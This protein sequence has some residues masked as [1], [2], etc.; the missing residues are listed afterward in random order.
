MHEESRVKMTQQAGLHPKKEA[1]NQ[2]EADAATIRT[3][4]AV[5]KTMNPAIDWLIRLGKGMLIG[6]GAILPGLSGGALS[7]IFGI[8][9]P[10]LAFLANLRHRFVRNV[11]FF[12][13]VILGGGL[14]ILFFS[15]VVKAAFGQYAAQFT[16]LFIGFVGGTF[17]SLYRT[18]GQQGR[19]T[20]DWLAFALAAGSVFILMLV[21]DRQLIDIQPN[22]PI[23]I[24]AGAVFGLGLIVPGMS[25]SNFL[26]YF[27]LYKKMADGIFALDFAVIIPLIIG[28]AACILLFSKLVNTLFRVAYPVMYHIILGL[29]VGSSLAILPTI[30]MPALTPAALA[31][32]GLSLPVAIIG[33]L[34]LLTIGI[35]AS[36]LF[37]KLENKYPH[38]SIF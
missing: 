24:I 1:R 17:P 6:I 9:T 12:L 3:N 34:I 28:L 10:L 7:V 27:G 35:I 31:V 36:Y 23:W 32:S 8:Y 33:C 18:A 11:L 19:R 38:E 26:I 37:S 22:V 2:S 16:C 4:R 15:G 29:V 30:V 25:P 21:G 5:E 13:P 20:R 14:G